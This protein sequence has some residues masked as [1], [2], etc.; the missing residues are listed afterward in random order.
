MILTSVI[1]LGSTLRLTES[2]EAINIVYVSLIMIIISVVLYN[3]IEFK[4]NGFTLTL[5]YL[6]LVFGIVASL[7]NQDVDVLM[8]TIVFFILFLST[9]VFM[10][11][12]FKEKTEKIIL[13]IIV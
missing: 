1:Y 12:Y 7:I 5:M 11:S 6:F 2:I 9:N 13:R 8:R 10:P 3:K 4:Y